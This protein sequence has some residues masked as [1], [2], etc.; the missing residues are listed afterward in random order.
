MYR[1]KLFSNA[2]QQINAIK[3]NANDNYATKAVS[4]IEFPWGRDLPHQSRPAVGSTK[5]SLKWIPGL[6]PGSKYDF[7]HCYM[8]QSLMGSS[9]GN[10]N[11]VT[12]HKTELV[13]RVHI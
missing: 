12:L 5:P 2:Y 3:N 4:S 6:F 13:I 9:A 10:H 11:K 7:K 8:F 1:I